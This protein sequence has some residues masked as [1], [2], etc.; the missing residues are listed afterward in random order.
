M[1]LIECMALNSGLPLDAASAYWSMP[2]NEP[3]KEK[4]AFSVP[5]G[6]YEF[7]VTPFGLCSAVASYHRMIDM[8]LSGLNSDRILAYM[9]DIVVF[10][11]T[12]DDHVAS[13]AQLFGRLRA[14]GILL[15]LSKCIFA[16]NK[17]D[18]L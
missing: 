6:K 9:D 16:S 12:F 13:I 8:S 4:T 18:F 11:K 5:R 15:K 3:D 2:L 14:S 7:N 1:L 10:S 17:V